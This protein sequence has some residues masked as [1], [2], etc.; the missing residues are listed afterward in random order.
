MGQKFIT[1]VSWL[2]EKFFSCLDI[3]GKKFRGTVREA[4]HRTLPQ[5]TIVPIWMYKQEG[6][7]PIA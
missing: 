4:P 1:K 3:G 5:I 6:N 7:G 2:V